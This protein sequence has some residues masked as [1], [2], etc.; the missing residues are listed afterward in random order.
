MTC[1]ALNIHLSL[2][3]KLEYQMWNT[4]VWLTCVESQTAQEMKIFL[5]LTCPTVKSKLK[6]ALTLTAMASRQV[7][8]VR[9]SPTG[10]QTF[11]TLIHIYR[12]RITAQLQ[13]IIL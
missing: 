6:S 5:T 9:M 12:E 13:P 1:K 8:T 3:D 2:K 7:H 11:G 4:Q 10:A